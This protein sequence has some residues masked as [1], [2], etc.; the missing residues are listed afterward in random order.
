MAINKDNYLDSDGNYNV[1]KALVDELINEVNTLLADM[2]QRP[3]V[4]YSVTW[5]SDDRIW[6]DKNTG[7]YYVG[8]DGV[9]LGYPANYIFIT[10]VHSGGSVVNQLGTGSTATGIYKRQFNETQSMDWRTI[11]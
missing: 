3:L 4:A 10:H 2:A 6:H 7:Y 9:T 5:R 8:G 1:K 11:Q